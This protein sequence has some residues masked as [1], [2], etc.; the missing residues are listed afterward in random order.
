AGR[1]AAAGTAVRRG[2]R[3]GACLR[4]AGGGP[5]CGQGVPGSRARCREGGGGAVSALTVVVIVI[6]IAILTGVYVS[7][8]AGRL[9]RLH[10][11]VETARA[12]LDAA[13]VRR[14]AVA[15]ELG[16]GGLLDLATGVLLAEAAHHARSATDG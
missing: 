14:S 9:D 8:R 4:L 3:S 10:T 13:L 11:R 12:S 15:L 5:G 7:W 1:P 6:A 16:T 2:L